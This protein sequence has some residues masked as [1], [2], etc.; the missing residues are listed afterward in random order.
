MRD[1]R[2]AV[3]K[4]ATA[5]I[6]WLVPVALLLIPVLYPTEGVYRD[7]F[8]L[9]AVL[10][11]LYVAFIL[12]P[13]FSP[14]RNVDF[15]DELPRAIERFVDGQRA[16]R[17]ARDILKLYDKSKMPNVYEMEELSPYL[18][19]VRRTCDVLRASS[20][21]HMSNAEVSGSLLEKMEALMHYKEAPEEE[22]EDKHAQK[23]KGKQ[24]R[25]H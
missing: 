17:D 10:I 11:M 8:I 12:T 13:M 16:R 23:G 2:G 6:I 19:N 15:F 25:S 7:L 1:D 4:Y 18:R 24:H 21:W 20:E 9:P 22:L 3:I 14:I 5:L